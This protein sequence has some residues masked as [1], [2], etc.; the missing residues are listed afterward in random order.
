MTGVQTCAL[1]ISSSQTAPARTRKLSFKE[2]RE[3]DTMEAAVLAAE[4]RA[5]VIEATL[6]DPKF[7]STRAAEATGFIAE[8]EKTKAEV[9]RLYARW[10]QLDAIGK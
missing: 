8:L 5:T 1:P 2:Q 3:L 10:E 6:A 7:F 9:A 4:T